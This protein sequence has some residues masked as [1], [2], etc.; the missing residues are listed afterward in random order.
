MRAN[1]GGIS[2][3]RDGGACFDETWLG[4]R[5]ETPQRFERIVETGEVGV[6]LVVERALD[7]QR[8]HSRIEGGCVPLLARQGR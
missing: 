5:F 4:Q 1:A 2:G 7:S 8:L 6:V 3:E